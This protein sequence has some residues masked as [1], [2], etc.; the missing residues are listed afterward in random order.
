MRGSASAL[1]VSTEGQDLRWKGIPQI[2]GR[3]GK[4]LKERLSIA[5]L[6]SGGR[7]RV[8]IVDDRVL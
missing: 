6:T 3:V 1:L 7:L 8:T 2:R 4:G 5:A